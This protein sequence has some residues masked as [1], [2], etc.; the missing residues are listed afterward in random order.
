MHIYKSAQITKNKNRENTISLSLS[1]HLIK[2]IH[3]PK[4]LTEKIMGG[5]LK[6]G[7]TPK[8]SLIS[9]SPAKRNGSRDLIYV[10]CLVVLLKKFL[11]FFNVF[12]K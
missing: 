7:N 9:Q 3:S 6:Y 2:C 5:R 12:K 11:F 8:Y 4:Q 1:R 10:V